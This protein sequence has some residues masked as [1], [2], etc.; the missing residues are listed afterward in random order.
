[1]DEKLIIKEANNKI[2][3][4]EYCIAGLSFLLV[5]GCYHQD[6]IIGNS[7]CLYCPNWDFGCKLCDDDYNYNL[8]KLSEKINDT[9]ITQ[10]IKEALTKT[11]TNI[12]QKQK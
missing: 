9:L 3:T 10:P 12:L 5:L 11:I 8:T 2:I 1:M 4:A 7:W 6:K